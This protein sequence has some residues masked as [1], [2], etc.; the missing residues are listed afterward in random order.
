[1][2]SLNHDRI[3]T[4]AHEISHFWWNRGN[5]F[6]MEKWLNES[7]AEY[8]ELLYV[9][10]TEGLTKFQEKITTLEK[11]SQ[12]LP[13][14][15]NSDRFGKN[16]SGVLYVKGPYLLYKLEEVLGKEKFMQLLSKLNEEEVSKTE[17]MLNALER[18]SSSEVR[19][20]FYQKL[21]E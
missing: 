7:F 16:W 6:T 4:L 1:M 19:E 21:I 9:R 20:I 3:Y 18:L 12:G 17:E 11:E 8:S 5:D 14:I 13:S 15:L 2:F 10:H